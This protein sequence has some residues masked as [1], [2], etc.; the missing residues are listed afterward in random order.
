VGHI[1]YILIVTTRLVLGYGVEDVLGL[2]MRKMMRQYKRLVK[3]V[4]PYFVD[5]GFLWMPEDQAKDWL[6]IHKAWREKQKNVSEP[7]IERV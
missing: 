7:R 1:L 5:P 6:E 3:V 4:S 2:I